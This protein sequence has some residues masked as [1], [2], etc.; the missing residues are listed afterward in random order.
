M[1]RNKA[2]PGLMRFWKTGNGEFFG[3]LKCRD[4]LSFAAETDRRVQR[5]NPSAS[6]AFLSCDISFQLGYVSD[7]MA[8]GA[9]FMAPPCLPSG[10]SQLN[11]P[12]AVSPPLVSEILS[13]PPGFL[14]QKLNCLCLSVYA[15]VVAVD[16]KAAKRTQNFTG[17]W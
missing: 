17:K 4:Y 2:R 15:V 10:S 12:F 14:I 7:V 8:T 3:F 1:A 13:A 11:K 16:L 9:N 5:R 6:R